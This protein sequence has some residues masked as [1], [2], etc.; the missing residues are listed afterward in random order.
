MPSFSAWCAEVNCRA[1]DDN[2]ELRAA[3]HRGRPGTHCHCGDDY[4]HD[5]RSPV[6]AETAIHA[7]WAARVMSTEPRSVEMT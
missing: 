2:W 7:V 6:S 4:L 5:A 3:L 1:A